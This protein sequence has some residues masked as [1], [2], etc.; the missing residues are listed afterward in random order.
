MNHNQEWKTKGRK[1]NYFFSMTILNKGPGLICISCHFSIKL[2]LP[3]QAETQCFYISGG[4]Y[5]WTTPAYSGL[6]STSVLWDHAWKALGI[7]EDAE[8]WTWI[9]YNLQGK[10]S[11]LYYYSSTPAFHIQKLFNTSDRIHS[12]LSD[13]FVANNLQ[14]SAYSC[15]AKNDSLTTSLLALSIDRDFRFN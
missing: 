4:C 9:W 13:L 12:C 11:T 5:L 6:S 1:E 7:L 14:I 15:K 2:Y 8:N 10:F 3:D